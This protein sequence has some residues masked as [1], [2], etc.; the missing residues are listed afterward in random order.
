MFDYPLWW[1]VCSVDLILYTGNT[2]YADAYWDVLRKTLDEFY[3]AHTNQALGLLDKSADIGYG[4]YAFLPRSGPVTYYNAL[5][6]HALT[7]AA[8]LAS[9]LGHDDDADRWTERA[10][11]MPQNLVARNFD[12]SSGAFFD[13]GPCPNAA[14]GTICNVHAQ[15]GNSIVILAGVT[16]TTL[17]SSI[18][19]YWANNTAQPYGNAFYDSSVLS[20]GD[21][22]HQ[23]VYALTSFFELAARFSTPGSEA[24][25]YEE[26]RRLYG[27][28]ASHD[29]GV[30]QWEGI[31][32]G[33]VSYQGPFMSYSHGWSTGIVPLMS[34]YV[35]GVKPTAPGF[36]SWK[37]CPA[38]VGD[39]SWAKGV[40]PT[41]NEGEIKVSWERA[42]GDAVESLKIDIETPQG[43]QGTIC[44]PNIG[45][46]VKKVEV[47]GEPKSSTEEIE[48]EGGRY[49]VVIQ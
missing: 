43:T 35:L 38:V 15:D 13:G 40:V 21:A 17:S 2:T 34:N 8:S 37:V 41:A 1:V 45:R 3:P 27:W 39:L 28:M 22:F 25:A 12:A 9:K 19:N 47:N 24:S 42:G 46:E 44:I 4:D 29:P 33:G 26:I 7:Y 20:P 23:R 5:Y 36:S 14:A 16:N 31:G 6:I 49:T 48:V 10:K 11:P 32:P 30:T 18:L